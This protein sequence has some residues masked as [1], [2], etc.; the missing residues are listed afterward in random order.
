MKKITLVLI[1]I[2]AYL[3]VFFILSFIKT[4]N[5]EV[6]VKV[7]DVVGIALDNKTLNF[8]TVPN[9]SNAFKYIDFVNKDDSKKYIYITS[10]GKV[11]NWIFVENNGFYLS[12]KTNKTIKIELFIPKDTRM[13]EYTGKMKVTFLG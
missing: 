5:F 3:V 10:Q 12:P 8:G 13:G 4:Q 7:D 1:G 2:I 6:K 9:G 11:K